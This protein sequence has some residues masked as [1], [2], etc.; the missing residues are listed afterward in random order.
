MSVG[1]AA[2]VP[3]QLM[4][5]HGEA[6]RQNS[7]SGTVVVSRLPGGKSR[8][9][10][11]A[12]SVKY[13][14]GGEE[15]YSVNGRS[16]RLR[17]GEFML[18][19]GGAE[20]I[21]RTSSSEGAVGMCIYLPTSEPVEQLDE[22]ATPMLAG[23]SLHPLSRLLK[24]H[25]TALLK[26]MPAPAELERIVASI[27]PAVDLFLRDFSA[28]REKLGH[29]RAAART[30]ALQRLERGRSWIHANAHRPVTLNEIAREA[31]MSPFHLTRTFTEVFGMAPLSY[32]RRLR[33][34]KAAAELEARRASPSELA[35]I[36]GY[37][38]LS[39]FTR[40]FTAEFG[41][42]PSRIMRPDD[43]QNRNSG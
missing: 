31:A 16:C 1:S 12:P 41:V 40:A 22:L 15:T 29:A 26:D 25:A 11:R 28:T 38:C 13:V 20:A 14:L 33:L 3:L 21:V 37:S 19:E 43:T 9:I 34:G 39:A 30:E 8:L 4:S 17:G 35:R 10:A 36:L 6:I 24:R 32:H 23:T 2:S 7:A 18:L 27:T 5:C 42:P